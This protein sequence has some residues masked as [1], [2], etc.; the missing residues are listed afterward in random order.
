MGLKCV[1][2]L[3]KDGNLSKDEIKEIALSK[4]EKYNSINKPNDNIAMVINPISKD[5]FYLIS[6][7]LKEALNL[8]DNIVEVASTRSDNSELNAK[9]A[10][11]DA[12]IDNE[13]VTLSNE[14]LTKASLENHNNLVASLATYAL[15][16]DLDT[17]ATKDELLTKANLSDLNTLATKDELLAKADLSNLDNLATKDE[18]NSYALK[19]EIN[20]SGG[21]IDENTLNQ[22]INQNATIQEL[23]AKVNHMATN[24]QGATYTQLVATMKF[25]GY[26]LPSELRAYADYNLYADD[27]LSGDLTIGFTPISY[28]GSYGQAWENVAIYNELGEKLTAKYASISGDGLNIDAVFAKDIAHP[29][30]D[31]WEPVPSDYILADGEVRVSITL[32]ASS[33]YGATYGLRMLNNNPSSWPESFLGGS[34]SYDEWI[35]TFHNYKPTKFSITN[36]TATYGGYGYM[37]KYN[38]RLSIGNWSKTLTYENSN[39]PNNIEIDFTNLN[40]GSDAK[41]IELAKAWNVPV[42]PYDINSD[43]VG[44]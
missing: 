7:K 44:G 6:N 29:K 43:M 12:K 14:I 11:L 26:E 16:S 1:T 37:T 35:F 20:S 33:Y 32:G 22:A 39:Y 24:L 19:S 31:S 28:A 13:I 42:T 41:T 23:G 4:L 30:G 21:S 25:L 3:V 10:E 18:L 36:G 34:H 5:S 9:I 2:M 17:L 8:D 38:M 15:K 27:R 40:F